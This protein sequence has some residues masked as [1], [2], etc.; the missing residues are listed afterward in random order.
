MT[1]VHKKLIEDIDHV[2][3][4]QRIIELFKRPSLKDPDAFYDL[5]K[6]SLNDFENTP[7]DE[8]EYRRQKA[9][10][11]SVLAAVKELHLQLTGCSKSNIN[12]INGYQRFGEYN[13][14]VEGIQ[15]SSES[16]VSSLRA[17]N[18]GFDIIDGFHSSGSFEDIKSNVSNVGTRS[19]AFD[20]IC[21]LV[22][23]NGVSDA[24]KKHSS[25]SINDKVNGKLYQVLSEL[26]KDDVVENSISAYNVT[27]VFI[28][29][30][31]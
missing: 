7:L 24:I 17:V 2:D 4:K 16:F 30:I 21:A 25:Y 22:L 31:K 6:K 27:K 18:T 9:E 29:K 8:D 28:Q 23:A 19:A 14:E 10:I 3:V 13:G 15:V 11:E 20:T 26:L 12:L 5:I 1:R